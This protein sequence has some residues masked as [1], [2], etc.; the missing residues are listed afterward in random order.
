MFRFRPHPTAG[1]TLIEMA[2]A[3]LIL[4]LLFGGVF[5]SLTVQQEH[6]RRQDTRQALEQAREALLGYAITHNRLPCPADGS[7]PENHPAA[8]REISARTALGRCQT[9]QG[10]LPWAELGLKQTDGWGR[11]YTYRV[12]AAFTECQQPGPA[13]TSEPPFWPGSC[14][15]AVTACGLNSAKPCFTLST[16]ADL[17]I[18]S[19]APSA[20]PAPPATPPTGNVANNVPAVI[21]SHGGHFPGSYG[22]AGGS[23]LPGASGNQAENSDD[24]R[25]FVSRLP[26][27]D[28]YDDETVWLS[29]AVLSARLI[30]AGRLP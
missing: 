21:V 13:T 3:L 6:R 2:L 23:P 7:L 12:S 4:G 20:C 1:F 18:Y 5:G 29:P 19:A 17:R 25:C 8:G 16:V 27:G 10:V 22:P 24:N 26:A 11:R 15:N 30:T 28:D 14:Q 9:L